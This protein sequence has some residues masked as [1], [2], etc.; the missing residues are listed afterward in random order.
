MNHRRPIAVL[1]AVTVLVSA[2]GMERPDPHASPTEA[3]TSDVSAVGTGGI[4]HLATVRLAP[5]DGYD[6]L[7]FEFT[8]RVPGYTIGYRPLPAQADGS[9]NEIPLPEASAM[10]KVAL[11]PATGKGWGGDTRTHFGPSTVTAN[12]AEVTEATAAGDYE[13][14]LTWV[15]GLRAKVPFRVAAFQEPPRLVIDFLH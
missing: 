4:G 5:Q 7:V 13:A 15:V 10:L 9:G 12:T 6:R 14:V 11:T 2:C 3:S 1:V 8:D